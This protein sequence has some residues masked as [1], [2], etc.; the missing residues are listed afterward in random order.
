M[1]RNVLLVGAVLM[2]ATVCGVGGCHH[3]E[4]WQA[5]SWVSPDYRPLDIRRAAVVMFAPWAEVGGQKIEYHGMQDTL[6]K[7]KTF[8]EALI[9]ALQHCGVRIVEQQVVEVAQREARLILSK[10]SDVVSTKELASRLGRQLSLDTVFYADALSRQTTFQFDKKFLGAGTAEARMR[11]REANDR[12]SI[13]PDDVRRCIIVA[14]H[15]VGLSLRAVDIA[16][17]RITWV[18]YRNLAMA[19][20]YDDDRPDTLSNFSAVQKLTERLVSDLLGLTGARAAAPPPNDGTLLARKE[21]DSG[22]P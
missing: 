21:T 22:A 19:D 3:Y 1:T 18:G 8:A 5:D 15:S 4:V 2:A 20:R 16:T 9:I 6:Q 10:Q 17:G 12:G 7:N 11:Q 13:T 14:H